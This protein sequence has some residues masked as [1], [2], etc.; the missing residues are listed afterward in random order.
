MLT[1]QHLSPKG[2]EHVEDEG[3]AVVRAGACVLLPV[4]RVQ[5]QH[6]HAA[7]AHRPQQRGHLRR[8]PEVGVQEQPALGSG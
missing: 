1:T 8:A 6:Q 4:G 5:V 3:L 2:V 7:P